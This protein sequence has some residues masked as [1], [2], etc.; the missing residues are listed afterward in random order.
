MAQKRYLRTTLSVTVGIDRAR[1]QTSIVR[2]KNL[3]AEVASSLESPMAGA[4]AASGTVT[5]S[6]GQITTGRVLVLEV[7]GPLEVRLNGAVA[8]FIVEPLSG[9]SMPGATTAPGRLYIEGRITGLVLVNPSS[10]AAVD[11]NMYLMGD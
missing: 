6:I 9:A 4:V 3:D 11:F 2:D 10:T 5:P 8:G 7:F 1:S